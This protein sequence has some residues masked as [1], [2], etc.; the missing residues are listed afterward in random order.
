M[1]DRKIVSEQ[2]LNTRDAPLHD[3][4]LHMNSNCVRTGFQNSELKNRGKK[5]HRPF[6]I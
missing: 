4:F 3:T 2:K 5:E 1:R 6:I